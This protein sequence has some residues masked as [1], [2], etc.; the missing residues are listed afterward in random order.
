MAVSALECGLLP[1]TQ[2]AMYFGGVGYHDYEGAGGRP[3]RAEAPGA[4]PRRAR[5]DDPAQ[6][7]PARRSAP[8]SPRPSSP[9]TGSSAPARRRSWRWPATPSCTMPTQ[10]VVETTNDRYKPGQRRNIGAARVAG[11]AAPGRQD[12]TRAS[13]IEAALEG[14]GRRRHRRGRRHRARFRARHGRRRR[15]GGGQ[16]R[17]HLGQGRRQRRRAGAEGRRR[18]Q[19][20]RRQAVASTDS[21]AEW[22]SANRI[23]QACDG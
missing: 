17:R 22:E 6:P 23:V 7:R 4:R 10:D 16:R 5:G 1:L 2:N 12:A 9:C 18:D 3:R 19:G 15:E 11:A 14:K 21:V 13:A 8:R 20:A